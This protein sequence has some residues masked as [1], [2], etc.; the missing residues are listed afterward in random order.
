M[1]GPTSHMHRI[2]VAMVLLVPT[3]IGC[4]EEHLPTQ[5]GN[6]TG[7]SVNGTGVLG[8]MFEQAGHSVTSWR[9]LSPRLRRADTIVWFPD[10]YQPPPP[11]VRQWF[12]DWLSESPGRTLVYVGR[13]YN[14]A[15]LY[16]RSVKP[17]APAH[18]SA[19]IDRRLN[20]AESN[21]QSDRAALPKPDDFDW[22][23]LKTGTKRKVKTLSGPWSQGIDPTRAEI[24]LHSLLSRG[25]ADVM[26]ESDGGPEVL[27]ESNGDALVS[28]EPFYSLYS[29]GTYDESQLIVV[30]NG[31][32]LLNL[33]LLNH[34][35]RKLAGKLI[36]EVGPPGRTVFLES[37]GDPQI[38][39][40]DPTNSPPSGL[41]IFGIWPMSFILLHLAALGIIFCFARYP[42]F[43]NPRDPPAESRSDFGKHVQALG[44]LLQMTRDRA[45]ALAR[46]K[47]YHQNVRGDAGHGRRDASTSDTPDSDTNDS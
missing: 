42:I 34:E 27:L 26:L 36:S 11:Q 24:E 16:W 3:A 5:Y 32:F 45:Y 21:E 13:D 43:G 10:S 9:T 40:E 41:E 23:S 8:D 17:G 2:I 19:E 7:N 39:D 44:E 35:H 25:D 20:M 14:A 38:L 6:R 22:F 15:P 33:P 28:R 46:L 47:H 31:S 1:S 37:M 18:L 4:I 12:E 29:T 30:T